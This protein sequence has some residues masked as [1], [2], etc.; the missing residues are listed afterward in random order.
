MK[1]GE[2]IKELRQSKGL[3]QEELGKIVGV[4]RAAVQKWENGTVTNLK[5]E[6]IK[7]LADYFDVEPASFIIEDIAFVENPPII[8]GERLKEIRKKKN[9]TLEILA[10]EYNKRY[11]GSLSKGTLSKYENG[12]QQPMISVVDN[13]AE[14]L[15]VSVDQLLG[16]EKTPEENIDTKFQ[17]IIKRE[18]RPIQMKKFPM[19]GKIACGKPIYASEEYETYIEAS[20]EI[21]ADFCLTAQGDSMINARIFDGDIVFIRSQPVVENGE[22][23]AVIIED[24]VTLKRFY[25]YDDS[26]E[27]R[28]ENPMYK[29]MY[30]RNEELNNIRILGKA[31]AFQSYLM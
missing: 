20:A 2:Y 15:D 1:I 7:K 11:N 14:L 29:P 18:L 27:L 23:A 16:K 9:I 21:N 17:E 6:T 8:F 25:K 22:I 13:L 4:Q 12:K 26:V 3:S 19:L 31:V 28:A 10:E 5:R 24:E 30:F